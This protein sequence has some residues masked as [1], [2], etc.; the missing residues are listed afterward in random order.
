M[1][2]IEYF[3]YDRGGTTTPFFIPTWRGDMRLAADVV[4]GAST[5]QIEDSRY[6]IASYDEQPWNAFLCLI[7]ETG[8]YPQ[9]ITLVNQTT[10]TPQVKLGK[11]FAK[12]TT[13]VSFLMLV[14]FAEPTLRWEYT[15][16]GLARVKIKFIEVP[17]EY[18]TAAPTLSRPA[19]LFQFTEKTPL[20]NNWYFTSYENTL[21]YAGKPYAPAPFSFDRYKGAR[22]LSDELTL[23]SWGGDFTANPLNQ[24]LPFT[25]NAIMTL[26]ITRVNASVPDDGK[27]RILFHGDVMNLDTSGTEWTALIKFFGRRLEQKFPR[28]LY[29]TPDNFTQ[30]TPPTQLADTTYKK[31]GTIGTLNGFTVTVN[32]L[33]EALDWWS[34]GR[35]QTGTGANFER[36]SV[37]K[38]TVAGTVQTITLDRPLL[39][40]VA[41]QGITLWPGYDQSREQCQ[42]KFNNNVNFGGHPFM[43]DTNVITDSGEIKTPTGGKK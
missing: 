35:I 20:P 30:F 10:I 4:S 3:F 31:I 32:G 37:L 19:F 43:P 6:E 40:A 14:R 7:D 22:D 12:A 8:V 25:L 18:T 26:T 27:A 34:N 24:F 11:S 28:H 33:S 23:T 15:S 17:D 41:G 38:S 29:Q 16:D 21:S 1:A 9:R 2:L 36:R 5:F 42:T 39:H 13:N